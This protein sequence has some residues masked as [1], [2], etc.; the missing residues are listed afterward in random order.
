MVQHQRT[1]SVADGTLSIIVVL[2]VLAIAAAATTIIVVT[3]ASHVVRLLIP[4]LDG[5]VLVLGLAFAWRLLPDAS[6]VAVVSGG[7]RR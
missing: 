1:R 5:L 6:Y 4:F 2:V 7:V 3:L